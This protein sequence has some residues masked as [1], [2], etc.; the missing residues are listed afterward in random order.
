MRTIK[1][2]ILLAGIL[3]SGC[4]AKLSSLSDPI[5]GNNT[6]LITNETVIKSRK[7]EFGKKKKLSSPSVPSAILTVQIDKGQTLLIQCKSLIINQNSTFL[8]DSG[9]TVIIQY[10]KLKRKAYHINQRLGE[11]GVFRMEKEQ[12]NF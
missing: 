8:C 10:T 3:S 11:N 9:A 1:L 5:Q 2:C 4:S 12:I 7:V 6:V